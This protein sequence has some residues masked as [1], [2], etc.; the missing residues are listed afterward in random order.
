M[1][2]P[3]VALSSEP[4]FS[5]LVLGCGG[6]PSEDDLSAFWIKPAGASWMDGFTSVDGGE[7]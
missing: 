6:G 7:L 1:A 4:A 3:H 2:A 5:M